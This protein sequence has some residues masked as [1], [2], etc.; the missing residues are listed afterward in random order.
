MDSLPQEW[1]NGFEAGYARAEAEAQTDLVDANELMDNMTVDIDQLEDTIE[2]LWLDL[3][4]M[5]AQRNE[6]QM[7]FESLDDRVRDFAKLGVARFLAA[8]DVEETRDD[9]G[10]GDEG[11][12]LETYVNDDA[13]ESS[14]EM[15]EENEG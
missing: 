9:Y 12:E 11:M 5:E 2:D 3:R 10:Y 15:G 13:Y 6:W 8:P 7:R 4:D 1:S 14:L